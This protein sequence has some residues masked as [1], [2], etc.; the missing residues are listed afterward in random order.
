MDAVSC[1]AFGND[2]CRLN[3][4]ILIR[5]FH[6]CLMFERLQVRIHKIVEIEDEAAKASGD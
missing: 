2:G 3:K 1:P 5:Q 6:L 4:I